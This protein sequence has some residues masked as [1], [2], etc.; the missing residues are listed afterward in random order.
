MILERRKRCRRIVEELNLIYFFADSTYDFVGTGR[1]LK[2]DTYPHRKVLYII[3]AY[4]TSEHVKS[5]NEFKVTILSTPELQNISRTRQQHDIK[6]SGLHGRVG[7]YTDSNICWI[8]ANLR[9][10]LP[11]SR[12]NPMYREPVVNA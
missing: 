2:F 12:N 9:H 11:L 6:R 7:I 5:A 1:I 4:T 3:V 10:V 8:S